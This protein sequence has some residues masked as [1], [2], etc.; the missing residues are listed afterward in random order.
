MH[1]KEIE[2]QDTLLKGEFHCAII[3]LE[4]PSFMMRFKAP[5]KMTQHQGNY[6]CRISPGDGTYKDVME[7]SDLVLINSRIADHDCDR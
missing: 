7:I 3:D 5:W 2:V 1:T 6:S 4:L